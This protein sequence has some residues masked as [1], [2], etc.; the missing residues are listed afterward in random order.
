M[1]QRNPRNPKPPP[2]VATVDFDKVIQGSGSS[3]WQES[4]KKSHVQSI[5]KFNQFL[6]HLQQNCKKNG[7]VE[8]MLKKLFPEGCS[9]PTY[10]KCDKKHIN[11]ELL[12]MY[13]RYMYE[14]GKL[15][16]ESASRYLS[17]LHTGLV[18]PFRGLE[19]PI[20]IDPQ[21]YATVRRGMRSLFV[22]RAMLTGQSLSQSHQTSTVSEIQCISVLCYWMADYEY[23]SMACFVSFLF[24]LTGRGGEI[25]QLRW[26][27]VKLL[28]PT[29]V[30]AN[31][32]EEDEKV[33]NVSLWREKTQSY[34]SLSL[35]P[36]RDDPRMCIYFN[37]AYMM[38]MDTG[39][40]EDAT[41]DYVLAGLIP[42][43]CVS[44][45]CFCLLNI[46]HHIY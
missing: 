11:A 30:I 28:S 31:T 37:L 27:R 26:D 8:D 23:A 35:F 21:A 9:V 3:C 16:Y 2:G 7:K 29:E 5:K 25:S 44:V 38:V 42:K 46:C 45:L 39:S 19:E 24:H 40:C 36:H 1:P 13:A 4:S 17:V 15:K 6:G 43:V 18:E 20:K 34:Q 33:I 12:D 32:N 14:T 41:K 10:E 22:A